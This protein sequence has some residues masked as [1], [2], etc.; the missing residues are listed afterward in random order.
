MVE[1][2]VLILDDDDAWL[3]RHRGYLEDAGVH[4][5][6]TRLAKEAINAAKTNPAIKFAI[7]DEVLYV[8][9]VPANDKDRELQRWQGHGVVREITAQR[10]DL[11]IIIVSSAPQLSS[12]ASGGSNRAF[13]EETK[14]LRRQKCV[15]DIIH[16]QDIEEDP[17]GSYGW[18][19]DLIKKP[20]TSGSPTTATPKMLIGLGFTETEYAAMAEQANMAKKKILPMA[21]FFRMGGEPVLKSFFERA[22][23]KTV[24]VEMPGARKPERVST[25]KQGSS[26]FQIL[27]VLAIKTEKAQDVVIQEQEYQYSPRKAKK[28]TGNNNPSYDPRSVRD[29]AFEY[30]EEGGRRS[31]TGVQFEGH[32]EQTTRLK[33]AI[34][35]L[36][37]KLANLNLGA[38]RQLFDHKLDYKGY[39]PTFTLGI[40]V[41]AVRPGKSRRR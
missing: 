30:T 4:C 31:R 3:Y 20:Q 16:K 14:R 12:E 32:T 23:E 26:A 9:P 19:L 40:I 39:Q 37:Q 38:A 34:H 36:S 27:E 11:Q 41:Y 1:P 21:P 24:W 18:I 6:A 7:I 10:L 35:R 33:V 29:F 15:I 5:Y 17:D 2:N 28:A 13:R 8:P 25:I 22:K